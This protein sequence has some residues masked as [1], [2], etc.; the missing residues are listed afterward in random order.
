MELHISARWAWLRRNTRNIVMPVAEEQGA[1][2][3]A[4]NKQWS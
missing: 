1:H 4:S 3:C 2:V